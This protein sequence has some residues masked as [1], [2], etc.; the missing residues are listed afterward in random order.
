M[1][2]DLLV[3]IAWKSIITSGAALLL[4]LLFKNRS[5]AERS[6]IAHAG[7]IATVLLPA[8]V[9]ALPRWEIE[10]GTPIAPL[11]ESAA[12][13]GPI[14]DAGPVAEQ[15]ASFASAIDWQAVSVW[16]YA[17]GA[18][19]LLLVMLLAVTR[20]FALRGRANVLVE[21]SWISA[22]AHA[23]RRMGFKH[24]TALLVSS[25]LHS[26][27]SWGVLRPII[28]LN[29]EAV[30]SEAEAE[31]IIAHELAHVARMDWAKL[32]VA[33]AATALFWFNPL[34][35]LLAR[36]CHQLRE[37]AADDAVLLSDVPSTDYAALLVGAARHDSRGLLLAANGV[38]PSRS[39]LG[40]RVMRVLDAKLSRAPARIAWAGA[41][42]L[43]ALLISA[44]LSAL[45]AVSPMPPALAP[46]PTIAVS[47]ATASLPKADELAAT[48]A[49]ALPA[50]SV[51]A[52]AAS[53]AAAAVSTTLASIGEEVAEEIE[54]A[55]K[56]PRPTPEAAPAPQPAQVAAL[57]RRVSSENL[58]AMRIHGVDENYVAEVASISP[59]FANLPPEQLVAMRI[60][61]I[62]AAKLRA[63]AELGYG[64]LSFDEIITS[65]VHGIT[66]AYIK[67][68]ADLG[69]R[70]L[71]M[72]QLAAM[73]IHGVE[74]GLR[75]GYRRRRVP[76]AQRRPADRNA[77]PWSHSELHRRT[78]KPRLSQLERQPADGDAHPRRHTGLH[79]RDGEC[80]VLQSHCRSARQHAHPR[81]STPQAHLGGESEG[82]QV[83][84]TD[85]GGS[86]AAFSPARSAGAGVQPL[87]EIGSVRPSAVPQASA[88][89]ATAFQRKPN[90]PPRLTRGTRPRT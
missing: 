42:S 84:D 33:R 35:W 13:A 49:E 28:L 81:R 76:Q 30:S 75:Q 87:C 52:T 71:R 19:L 61:G 6:W 70:N 56:A 17:A 77:H 54:S 43:G 46:E 14:S 44:P 85:R 21:Q 66:P 53:T 64:N 78:R 60:H 20:L 26:P 18:V 55:A 32:L 47:V 11:T 58:I 4:L 34:V 39:S 23:Q 2:Y 27:V 62:S 38:A 88:R 24:G 15:T 51:S 31:A 1:S 37:E 7:L 16:V 59:R 41:C 8:A 65:G 82:G 80:R 22:L 72:N 79:P 48:V 83:R 57:R 67:E 40:R 50:S 36:Q 63:L 10:T 89:S 3:E 73:R 69:Y 90:H 86:A 5:A 12:P 9:I 25:E 29:E 68:V 45:T 74:R